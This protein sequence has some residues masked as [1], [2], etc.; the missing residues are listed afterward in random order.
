MLSSRASAVSGDAQLPRFDP[1]QINSSVSALQRPF[2]GRNDALDPLPLSLV[3]LN[4][5]RPKHRETSS[6]AHSLVRGSSPGYRYQ[7]AKE[8]RIDHFITLMED[9]HLVDI[10]E[11]LKRP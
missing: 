8:D 10:A 4:S 2:F 11:K 7:K 9:D 3:D 6:P 5:R 1:F